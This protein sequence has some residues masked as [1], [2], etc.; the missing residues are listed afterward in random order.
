LPQLVAFAVLFVVFG[1]L[2][3]AWPCN[4]WPRRLATKDFA[5]DVLFWL[6]GVVFY[7]DVATIYISAG[8]EIIV[9]GHTR[10]ATAAILAGYGPA[11]RLPLWLQSIAAL[12]ALDLIQYWVHRLFH[13]RALWPFHAVH[14]SAEELNWTA[15][16]RIHPVNFLIYNGGAFAIVQLIGFSPMALAPVLLFNGLM[17]PLVHANLNWTFGPLR[18]VLA[19]PVFHR[20]H[21][22]KDPAIHDKNFAPNFPVFDIIFGTFYMP[23]GSLPSD[24]G[25]EG[26]PVRFLQQLIYP[27]REIG[28]RIG[29]T[30]KP[31]DAAAVAPP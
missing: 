11:L 16:F 15:T 10:A 21:H 29:A 17:G 4:A 3:R 26:V 7:G 30:P 13:G 25:V 24:Y 22:V 5:D 14:H 23:K 2:A 9:P 28:R 19:S 27:F 1:A 6:L 31:Q 12:L 20:W 18:Y 8:A